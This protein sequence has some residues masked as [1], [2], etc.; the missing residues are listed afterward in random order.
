EWV[1]G[2]GTVVVDRTRI[3][4][5]L[6]SLHAQIR[7]LHAPCRVANPR[8]SIANA[9]VCALPDTRIHSNLTA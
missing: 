1:Y 6:V 2:L 7:R 3:G 8:D 4:P 9:A 5:R